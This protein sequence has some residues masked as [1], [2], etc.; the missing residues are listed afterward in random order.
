MPMQTAQRLGARHPGALRWLSFALLVGLGLLGNYAHYPVFLN[1]DFLFGSVAAM[2]AVQLLGW[3]LG[4]L[5]AALIGSYTVVLWN[6]PYA[7]LIVTAEAAFVGLL[8]RR[9]QLSLVLADA[10]YWVL[11]GLPA[12]YVF[13]GLVMEV[14]MGSMALVMVKQAINGIANALLARLLF[15]LFLLR[16]HTTPVGLRDMSYNLLAFFALCPALVLLAISSRNDVTEA[17]QHLRAEMLQDDKRLRSLLEH[18]LQERSQSMVLLSHMAERL[19][20]APMQ[21]ALDQARLADHNFLRTGVLDAGARVL[22]YS[23]SV[24]ERGVSNVGKSFADRPFFQAIQQASGPLLSEVVMGRLGAPAPIVTLL[25]PVRRNGVYAGYVSGVLSLEH[26]HRYLDKSLGNSSL[27]YLVLDKR[28]QVI[29]GNRPD[30]QTM[31]RFER[32]PGQRTD[33]ADGSFA[34]TPLQVSGR[35]TMEQWQHSWQVTELPVG[36]LG[37]WRLVLEQPVAPIQ[38]ALAARYTRLLASL[39]LILLV[40]LLLAEWMSRRTIA[41]LSRLSALTHQLP[42]KLAQQDLTIAWPSS[43]MAETRALIRNFKLMAA[44]LSALLRRERQ[45]NDQLDAQVAERTAALSHSL[46]DKE[47]LLREVHHRVKNNLQ[48]ITSMLRLESGR[49]EHQASRQVLQD[50]QDRVRSMALLHETVYRVGSFAAIDLGDYLRQVANQAFRALHSGAAGIQLQLELGQ[51]SV[52][53]DQATPCG[54]LA[55]ELLSNC[56]KHAFPGGR[57]GQIW[58]ELQPLAPDGMWRLRVRDDGVGLGADFAARRN[59]GLG[60]KL[61]EGL[62]GQIG[63]RLEVGPGAAFGVVFRAAPITLASA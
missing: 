2:L 30:I 47:A 15:T 10:L 61:V 11:L 57:G 39:L 4:V 56:F 41:T 17:R 20:P 55:N 53:L 31:S 1:I 14:P 12:T 36:A 43:G 27:R 25:V 21:A 51:L 29:L 9:Y 3:R 62:A 34:W 5:A 44:S 49:S 8:Y 35:P 33:F 63:G 40:A 52:G 54:L 59:A 22:H 42:E 50:M 23:P 26:L 6:H 24:D 16:R 18:W 7:V 46:R 32:P 60:L 38:K 45:I 37:E 48:V 13:Y 58:V 28:D 19:P